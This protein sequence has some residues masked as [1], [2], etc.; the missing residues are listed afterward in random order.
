MC[1]GIHHPTRGGTRGGKDQFDWDDVKTDKD[2]E[3]YLGKTLRVDSVLYTVN[4]L[5]MDHPQLGRPRYKYKIIFSA[6]C[7]HLFFN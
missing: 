7:F 2:R 4:F 6:H 1:A 3:C 5:I